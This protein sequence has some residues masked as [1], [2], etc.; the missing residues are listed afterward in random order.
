[1]KSKVVKN[2]KDA[3]KALRFFGYFFVLLGL[4]NLVLYFTESQN[5]YIAAAV[6]FGMPGLIFINAASNLNK[7]LK[8]IS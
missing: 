8:K 6:F 1:M 5:L 2:T 4:G 7:R 3:I